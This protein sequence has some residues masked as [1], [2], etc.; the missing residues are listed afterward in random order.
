MQNEEHG[1]S[2]ARE[3][4]GD[5]LRQARCDWCGRDA[6]LTR[7][8]LCRHCNDIRKRIESL[9]D[10]MR[11]IRKPDFLLDCDLR[12]AQAEKRDC[13]VWGEMLKTLL[14]RVDALDLEHWLCALAKRIA[15]DKRTHYNTATMLGWTFTA[16]QR[17]VLA[18]LFWEIL[19]AEAS[20]HRKGRA[21]SLRTSEA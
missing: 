2:Y 11:R 9:E 8:M 7:K 1:E 20:R 18:Y 17:Q 16:E 13:I 3:F 15:R 10:K 4:I 5:M 12:V 14:V 6:R 21:S 19:G